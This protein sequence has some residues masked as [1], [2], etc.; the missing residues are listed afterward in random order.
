[1]SVKGKLPKSV[2][3]VLWSYDVNKI[4]FDNHKKLIVAQVLNFGTK[5]A[6]DWLFRTYGID[7]IRKV[8]EIIPMGQWD[9][10][11]LALWSLCLDIDPKPK[12]ERVTNG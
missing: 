2:E 3:N 7:Q 12:L 1:M 8:A 4:D 10:K 6:T 11:S 9:R 5:E